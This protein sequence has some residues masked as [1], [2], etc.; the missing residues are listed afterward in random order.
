MKP[1]P[2]PFREITPED[3]D[4]INIDV[5]KSFFNSRDKCYLYFIFDEFG[6]VV[7]IGQTQSLF[8]RI[9]T[10]LND[11]VLGVIGK[12]GYISCASQSINNAEA[13]HIVKLN[14]K[15]NKNLPQNDIYMTQESF[16][17]TGKMFNLSES[18]ILNYSEILNLER[19]NGY[20]KIEDMKKII[21]KAE[22]DKLMEAS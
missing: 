17:K 10:H 22:Q 13:Y 19:E 16:K 12:I 18:E 7:Y 9:C 4:T 14:P 2:L 1:T 8:S 21:W 20:F 5:P 3:L 6:T 15:F 11:N